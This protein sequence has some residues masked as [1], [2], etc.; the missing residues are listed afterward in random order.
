MNA[1]VCHKYFC[2]QASGCAHNRD[3]S[4]NPSSGQACSRSLATHIM[5]LYHPTPC[6]TLQDNCK[7]H[8]PITWLHRPTG[9]PLAATSCYLPPELQQ[10]PT[11]CLQQPSAQKLSHVCVYLMNVKTHACVL[12]AALCQHTISTAGTVL[13]KAAHT[14]ATQDLTTAITAVVAFCL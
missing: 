1:P 11:Q 9:W 3:T 8:L 2:A 13:H 7:L 12:N 10:L 6:Q 5:W 4:Q 14:K